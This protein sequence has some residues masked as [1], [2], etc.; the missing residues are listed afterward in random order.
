MCPTNF[1][2][3]SNQ[4]KIF[5][6]F[7][8]DFLICPMDYLQLCCSFPYIWEIS[9]YLIVA[10]AAAAKWLQSC[11]TLCDLIDSSPLGSPVPGIL[12]ARILEWVAISF[13]NTWKW[14][15]KGKLLSRARLLVTPWTAAY[16]LLC[17]NLTL[18]WS[19]NVLCAQSLEIYWFALWPST[20]SILYNFEL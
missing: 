16:R 20:W 18:L 9:K 14:K 6:N 1:S 13:S 3:L 8:C 19:D 10:T 5:S 7:T 12:R 11:P 17:P 2:V 4:L 15:A